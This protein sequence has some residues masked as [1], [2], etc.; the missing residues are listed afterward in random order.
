MCVRA[1]IKV[2]VH[3]CCEH[4]CLYSVIHKIPLLFEMYPCI[5]PILF[6]ILHFVKGV[7]VKN[8][9]NRTAA[10]VRCVSFHNQKNLKIK[11][12]HKSD[13]KKNP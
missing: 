3:V 4:P 13:S 8:P 12:I 1:F 5:F 6:F 9:V 11:R 10:D 2:S 7:Y